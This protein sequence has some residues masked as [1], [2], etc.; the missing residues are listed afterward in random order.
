MLEQARLPT[1]KTP[2][3]P[4]DHGPGGPEEVLLLVELARKGDLGA[5]SRL[6]RVLAPRVAAV[7]RVVMGPGHPD[8]DDAIQQSL[9]ALL[10]ALPAFRG[11]CQ[12][13]SYASRIAARVAV[14]ARRRSRARTARHE[15]LT[16]LDRESSHDLSPADEASATRRKHLLRELLG[17]LPEEQ[18]EAM[19]LR[20]VLGWSLEEVAAAS[21][22]P[23]NTIRSRLRLAREAMRRR[24]EQDPR[25]FE[26]LEAP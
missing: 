13:S 12:P 19:T 21:G 10:Q 16:A 2:I 1:G 3:A 11:E 14:A 18:A 17:E 6:L 15:E 7:V 23:V 4:P 5:T 22:A 8:Q 9:I 26:E 24:I 20:I 25:L